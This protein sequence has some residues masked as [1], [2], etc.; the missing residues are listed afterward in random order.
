[1][2]AGLVMLALLLAPGVAAAEAGSVRGSVEL[3]LEGALLADVAPVVVYLD[4]VEGPL[5]FEVPRRVPTVRQQ[6]ARFA[7]DFLVVT[8]GQTVSM[9]NDDAIYHNVFSYSK[10][11]AFDLGVYPAGEARSV[12]LR[13]AGVVRTYCSIHES[14]TGTILVAPSPWHAIVSEAGRFEL[15]GV[16]PGRYRLWVWSARLPHVSQLVEVSAGRPSTPRIVIGEASADA[17]GE[18]VRP[19]LHPAARQ[20][21]PRE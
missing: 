14:M 19:A 7:P 11:N 17:P 9:P 4:G 1:M 13:H 2:R 21:E 12:T 18:P 15:R 10:P 3:A 6:Q 20:R 8:A 5:Q 16:P